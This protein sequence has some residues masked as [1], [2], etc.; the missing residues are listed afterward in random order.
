MGRTASSVEGRDNDGVL[1]KLGSFDAVC[2]E[3][4]LKGF[5]QRSD[6]VKNS[7]REEPASKMSN[8]G[9]KGT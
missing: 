8:M 2:W 9:V 5:A 6:G 4:S 3:D 1:C 7:L